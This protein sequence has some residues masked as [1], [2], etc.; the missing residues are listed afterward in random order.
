MT[1]ISLAPIGRPRMPRL[2]RA[3]RRIVSAVAIAAGW[4]ACAGAAAAAEPVAP[5][6]PLTVSCSLDKPL[7]RPGEAAVLS[8]A[9]RNTGKKPMRVRRLDAS[10]VQLAYNKLTESE[11]PV[12][13]D[14]VFSPNQSLGT[15]V[16]LAAGQETRQKF[17]YTRLTYY[18]GEMKAQVQYDPNPQG[19]F[20]NGTKVF[21]PTLHFEVGG[22][23]LFERDPTGL[24]LIKQAEAIKLASAQAQGKVADSKSIVVQDKSTGLYVTWVNLTLAAQAGQ[25]GESTIVSYLVDPYKGQVLEQA[26]PFN[27]AAADD[28]RFVRP[29][30]LPPKPSMGGRG[31]APAEAPAGDAGAA[32]AAAPASAPAPSV[33]APAPAAA[34]RPL[35]PPA[36]PA[37]APAGPAGGMRPP[38]AAAP[39]R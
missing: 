3:V 32:P 4:M 18:T 29:S 10:S 37:S 21:G 25:P 19:S 33:A 7:Y 26:K 31:G 16:T 2:R 39:G 13:R 22:A 36:S 15:L 35:A 8:V 12:Y 28:P 27:P 14:P 24:G 9:V 5:V 20:E 1:L 17:T 23:P 30:T 11:T 6:S 38:V 34:A